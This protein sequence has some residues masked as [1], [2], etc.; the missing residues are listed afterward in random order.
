MFNIETDTFN[1][2]FYAKFVTSQVLYTDKNKV[3][4]PWNVIIGKGS[5]PYNVRVYWRFQPVSGECQFHSEMYDETFSA[6]NIN[7]VGIL[8]AQGSA[9]FSAVYIY[10]RQHL[11]VGS[12]WLRR[13]AP[14]TFWC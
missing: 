14:W 9:D 10:T 2:T 13:V 5:I 8:A 3:D 12:W 1:K 7:K 6:I 4:K 11:F